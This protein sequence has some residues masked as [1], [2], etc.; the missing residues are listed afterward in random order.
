MP[1]VCSQYIPLTLSLS[2]THQLLS[3]ANLEHAFIYICRAYQTMENGD[4]KNTLEWNSWWW[5]GWTMVIEHSFRWYVFCPWKLW[6]WRVY[7]CEK[8]FLKSKI[9]IFNSEK[10][11][12]FTKISTTT[13]PRA[14]KIFIERSHF[15]SVELTY[16]RYRLERRTL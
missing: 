13:L 7:F 14:M 6:C 3:K 9:L 2:F 16:I 11:H 15:I 8:Y 5:W 1:V 4:F 10:L 12:I